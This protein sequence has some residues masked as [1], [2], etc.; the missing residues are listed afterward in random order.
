MTNF[1]HDPAPEAGPGWYVS[2]ET[3]VPRHEFTGA[4]SL[5]LFTFDE[6]AM[7][8]R[9]DCPDDC[10]RFCEPA[11][12]GEALDWALGHKCREAAGTETTDGS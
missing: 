8:S 4:N 3:P 9:L 5:H 1:K 10:G 11:N 12:L 2:D 7:S 6:D